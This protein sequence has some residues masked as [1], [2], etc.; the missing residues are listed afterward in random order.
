MRDALEPVFP[1]LR[2]I[3]LIDYRVRVLNP[4]SGSGAKVRVFVTYTDHTDTW[5]TVGVH[6]NIVEASW[7]A[8][9][10]KMLTKLLG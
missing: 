4:E 10:E 1:W 6:A 7:E 8:L 2:R 3:T 9:T 5:D